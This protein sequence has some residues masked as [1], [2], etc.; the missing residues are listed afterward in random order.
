[1]AARSALAGEFVRGVRR[2]DPPR[3]SPRRAPHAASIDGT[4]LDLEVPMSE[5][6]QAVNPSLSGSVIDE[7]RA[8]IDED[9]SRPRAIAAFLDGISHSER[10][11]AIRGLR[12][13]D[14]SRL[15]DAVDGF[16]AVTLCD[17]VPPASSAN[18]TVRH[19]G[20]NTLPAFTHFEKRFCRPEGEDAARP[21][22][23]HG[24][25]FQTM[26]P[27]TGPG[28]FVAVANPQRPDSEVW[29]DYN[30]VPDAHPE[31]W[32]DI[33]VNNRGLAQ[34]VYGY[35]IDNLRRVSE[36]VTI[37]SAARKGKDLGSWFA[38]CREA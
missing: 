25:N 5:Q 13:K 11:T 20:K 35:M 31:G 36:H 26:A 19:F 30:R 10:V 21:G 3:R 28:Y 33:R 7:L 22:E 14:Q 16:E 23:L 34:F 17:I 12:R 37:G 15:Y 29:V 1:M 27:V 24:F 18:Q 8:R 38:L 4:L 32:P 6:T 2:T 9:A